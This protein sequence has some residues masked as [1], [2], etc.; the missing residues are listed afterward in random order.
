MFPINSQN[1]ATY[2]SISYCIFQPFQAIWNIPVHFLLILSILQRSG[3][4][5]IT[6]M[7]FEKS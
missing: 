7:I 5:T 6:S 2:Q 4:L 1:S 3:L